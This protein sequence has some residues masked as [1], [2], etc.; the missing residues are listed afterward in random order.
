MRIS[1]IQAGLSLALAAGGACAATYPVGI[2]APNGESTIA[3]DINAS[4]QVAADLRDEGGVERGVMFHR[5][6]LTELGTLGG[7]YSNTKAINDNGQIVGSAQ[8]EAGRWR[9]FVY[10]LADGMRDL[11]T[12]GGP[13]SYGLAINAKGEVAGFADTSDGYF[14]AFR[15]RDGQMTDIGTLG[16]NISYAAGLNDMGVVVGTAQTREGFR[17]AFIYDEAQGMRDLGTLGGR[18][19]SASAVND[20]GVVV[21]TSETAQRRWHAFVY[22]DG[23]MVDLGA[24]IGFGDSFATSINNAGHVVGTVLRGEERM[25]FVWRDGKMLVHPGGH[26][27]YLTNAITDD[28]QVVGAINARRLIASTMP[29]SSVP[30]VAGKGLHQVMGLA[31]VMAI[32]A[33]GLVIYRR[34]YQ[35]MIIR[36]FTFGAA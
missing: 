22:E 26:G 24:K 23:K 13:S 12:L 34:R 18:Q 4:G 17:H 10:T 31:I 7:L 30:V 36:S 11:G 8:T 1:C 2:K 19:S 21:G 5:G 27:L 32:L 28:E 20:A 25:S 33:G 14:R 3:Y 16:G 6:V 35:G 9:A 29:S 15:Y